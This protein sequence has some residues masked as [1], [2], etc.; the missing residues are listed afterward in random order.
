M[1]KTNLKASDGEGFLRAYHD[2]LK[3]LELN[4]GVLITARIDLTPRRG[5]LVFNLTAWSV[6]DRRG[7]I[8]AAQY[9]AEYPTAQVG[10]LEAF[11]Y[12]SVVKL[13]RVLS[14]AHKFPMGKG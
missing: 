3:D 10:T 13:G 4:F 12:Q 7:E 6:R 5:V 8:P 9:G 14:D 2:E 1:A 11:L